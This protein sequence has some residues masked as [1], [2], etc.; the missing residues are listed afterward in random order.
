MPSGAGAR[1]VHPIRDIRSR[2]GCRWL[3]E[4]S[5]LEFPPAM[6]EIAWASTFSSAF[7]PA[8]KA[9]LLQ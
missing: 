2:D 1:P 6:R 3:S 8:P 4:Q 7:A 9:T 5:R